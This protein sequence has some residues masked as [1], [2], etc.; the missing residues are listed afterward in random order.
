MRAEIKELHQRLG[1]TTIYVTHDQ[2]EA[3]T[4]ADRIVVMNGG[5]VEQIGRPLDLYDCPRNLF[6]A[7]FIGSP[8]MNLAE[9]RIVDGNFKADHGQ[10][11]FRVADVP[12]AL[13]GRAVTCGFRPE[14][15]IIG[16]AGS[17]ATIA[18]VE[19]TGSETQIILRVADKEFV[20][21][22]RE[23]VAFGPGEP[24]TIDVESKHLHLFDTETGLRV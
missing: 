19:P 8:S 5:I 17:P 7:S 2:I 10:L 21:L 9:G 6:V 16:S 15:L 18:I 22:S 23:R 24:V 12:S 20:C 14:N 4:M 11:T 1:T 3:M 13:Q